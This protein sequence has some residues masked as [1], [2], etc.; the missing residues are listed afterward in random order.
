MQCCLL[1]CTS[2]YNMYNANKSLN[3]D[4]STCRTIKVNKRQMAMTGRNVWQQR[5][6]INTVLCIITDRLDSVQVTVVGNG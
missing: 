4:R 1:I 5:E 2:L 6:R 3:C